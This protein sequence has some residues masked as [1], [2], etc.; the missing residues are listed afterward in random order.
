MLISA[1]SIAYSQQTKSLTDSLF[2]L[3]GTQ[4]V[5]EARDFYEKYKDSLQCNKATSLI[6]SSQMNQ[7]LNKPDSAIKSVRRL[8][9]EFD[10]ADNRLRL[11]YLNMLGSFYVDTEDYKRLINILDEIEELLCVSEMPEEQRTD[12]LKHLRTQRELTLSYDSLP[13]KEVIDTSKSGHTSV[14]F[15]VNPV[16]GCMV[17]C[18]GIPLRV[19]V[20]TGCKYSLLLNKET[21]EKYHLKDLNSTI[22][23]TSINGAPTPVSVSI[24]DSIRIGTF[25]LKNIKALVVHQDSYSTNTDEEIKAKIDSAFALQD[26]VIGLPVLLMFKSI[27]L[28]FEKEQ[29]RLSLVEGKKD[30][31]ANLFL[32]NKKLLTILSLNR[33]NFIGQIDTGGRWGVKIGKSFYEKNDYQLP[34]NTSIKEYTQIFGTFGYSKEQRL[35]VLAIPHVYLDSEI[36][37][38]KEHEVFVTLDDDFVGF[39]GIIGYDLLRKLSPRIKFDFENMRISTIQL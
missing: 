13:K 38:V 25:N 18:N 29:M 9:D 19:W 17:E 3:L 21:A 16:L 20:D 11:D 5:F 37:P 23:T 1:N 34:I 10:F 24:V 33:T 12:F 26:A 31:P 32:F 39:D 7:Y 36:I 28:D 6:Y 8:L 15:T 22:D 4:K 35:K 27:E 2:Y 14:P 30:L